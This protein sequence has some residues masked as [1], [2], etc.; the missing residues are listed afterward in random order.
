[1]NPRPMK[2]PRGERPLPASGQ[3]TTSEAPSRKAAVPRTRTRT[4]TAPGRALP[5]PPPNQAGAAGQEPAPS[6]RDG[7]SPTRMRRSE[8][9]TQCR[10][11]HRARPE[12]R[13]QLSHLKGS[14]RRIDRQDSAH[15]L[16]ASATPCSSSKA[17][18]WAC[19]WRARSIAASAAS[20][21]SRSSSSSK[22]LAW[23][24][25]SAM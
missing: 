9:K 10:L 21:R 15:R 11:R 6:P 22:N 18:V 23:P 1:M 8:T 5:G 25:G 12:G 2:K 4:R 24:R 19:D 3:H 7:S 17:G 13:A 20:S 14:L 16:G